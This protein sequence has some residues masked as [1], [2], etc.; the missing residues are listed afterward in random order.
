MSATRTPGVIPSRSRTRSASRLPSR[1]ASSEKTG[2]MMPATG[3]SGAGNPAPAA[4]AA[5]LTAAAIAATR[6]CQDGAVTR[7]AYR[8]CASPS[9]RLRRR[10][11]AGETA[12]KELPQALLHLFGHLD[13]TDVG[14][15]LLRPPV[16]C[17]VRPARCAF[18]EMPLEF[19]DVSRRHLPLEVLEDHGGPL[20]HVH[21][22]H[23][24]PRPTPLCPAG[25]RRRL[26][27]TPKLP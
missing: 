27:Q 21:R 15:H 19:L 20:S 2:E 14:G 6:R 12:E 11:L 16:G 17:Q 9:G 10:S 25:D 7:G 22:I 24:G 18:L 13:P 23:A 8:S 26:T 4:I 3:R 1:V 5:R